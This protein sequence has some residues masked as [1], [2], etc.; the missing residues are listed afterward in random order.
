MNEASVLP[1]VRTLVAVLQCRP[2]VAPSMLEVHHVL[3]GIL[4]L[5]HSDSMHGSSFAVVGALTAVAVPGILH[6]VHSDSTHGSSFVVVG[7]VP[8]VVALF[9]GQYASTCLIHYV[10]DLE[11]KAVRKPSAVR[12]HSP[13]ASL[14]FHLE[15]GPEHD[16]SSYHLLA[17]A[18]SSCLEMLVRVS[19]LPAPVQVPAFLSYLKAFA[20]CSCRHHCEMSKSHPA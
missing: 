18:L 5:V 19:P 14:L 4:H 1:A 16:L 15:V 8:A 11:L 10:Y 3:P 17:L 20:V 9:Q 12:L 2:C 13:S 7:A 6:L